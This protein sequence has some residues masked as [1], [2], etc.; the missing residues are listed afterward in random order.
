MSTGD[1]I[2]A[3]NE[4]ADEPEFESPRVAANRTSPDRIVFT[5]TGNTDGW[6]ATDLAVE[7]ER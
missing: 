1:G 7:L 4:A 5:E 6:I 3:D 2:G